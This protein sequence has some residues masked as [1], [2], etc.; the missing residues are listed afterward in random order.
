MKC[1]DCRFYSRSKCYGNS[2][3]CRGEKPCERK[4]K[5]VAKKKHRERINKKRSQRYGYE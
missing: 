5:D 1:S 2:C 4:H 3:T